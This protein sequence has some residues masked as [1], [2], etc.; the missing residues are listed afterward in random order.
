MDSPCDTWLGAKAMEAAMRAK[1][2]MIWK[3]FM[4]M[5]A[6]RCFLVAVK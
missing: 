3:V 4:V 1:R 5:A 6:S 2:E